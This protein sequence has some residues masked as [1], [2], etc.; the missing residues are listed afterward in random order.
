MFHRL[1]TLSCLTDLFVL[2]PLYG[3]LAG[4]SGGMGMGEPDAALV[5]AI[6]GAVFA[7]V[8]GWWIYATWI[9]GV[10]GGRDGGTVYDAHPLME[11]ALLGSMLGAIVGGWAGNPL[12]ALSGGVAGLLIAV[13]IH[14]AVTKPK[15]SVTLS[16]ND[17]R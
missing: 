16:V 8:P 12:L 3:F 10:F 14:F 5:G 17:G 1:F 7:L 4:M 2:T 13:G 9:L 15:K 6:L 11:W